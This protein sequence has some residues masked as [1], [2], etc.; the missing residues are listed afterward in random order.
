VSI[1]GDAFA[2]RRACREEFELYREAQFGAAHEACSGQLVNRLGL[3]RNV[4]AFSLFMGSADRA[5]LYATLELLDWWADHRRLNYRQ[6]E[7]AW[8]GAGREALV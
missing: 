3:H 4:S 8:V 2:L 7:E 1:V 6:F 5:N